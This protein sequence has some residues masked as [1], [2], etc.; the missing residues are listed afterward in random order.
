MNGLVSFRVQ[1]NVKCQGDHGAEGQRRCQKHDR[2]V[3]PGLGDERED[4]H[5]RRDACEIDAEEQGGENRF[6]CRCKL[7]VGRYLRGA[8]LAGIGGAV[9][10]LLGGVSLH[11]FVDHVDHGMAAH[12]DDNNA[13][14]RHQDVRDGSDL[15]PMPRP[16][17]QSQ[18]DETHRAYRYYGEGDGAPHVVCQRGRHF[19]DKGV[20]L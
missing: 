5:R 9:R 15:V 14:D 12:D 6:L 11:R 8:V 16:I 2:V 1:L 3:R 19:E 13:G 10:S 18:K 17:E 4:E 20:L 7:R